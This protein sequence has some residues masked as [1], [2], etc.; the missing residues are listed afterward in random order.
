[1]MANGKLYLMLSISEKDAL[2][3]I[4]STPRNPGVDI[5]RVMDIHYKIYES[6]NQELCS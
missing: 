6:L 1:M 4:I 3:W 5:L 2:G